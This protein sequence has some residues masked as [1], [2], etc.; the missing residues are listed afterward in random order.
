[1]EISGAKEKEAQEKNPANPNNAQMLGG[2]QNSQPPGSS[3]VYVPSHIMGL[4]V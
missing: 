1:M 4:L 3:P 2:K